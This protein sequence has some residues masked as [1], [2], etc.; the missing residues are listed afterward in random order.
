MI[1]LGPV[2]LQWM[3]LLF[4]LGYILGWPV[5]WLLSFGRYRPLGVSE[6][7][8][9]LKPLGKYSFEDE[10]GVVV[11]SEELTAVIGATIIVLAFA[12]WYVSWFGFS[13]AGFG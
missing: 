2:I 3:E 4:T 6:D 1:E 12:A 9:K 5:I 13:W 7:V 11:L 8:A 10:D